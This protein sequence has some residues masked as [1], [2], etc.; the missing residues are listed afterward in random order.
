MKTSSLWGQPQSRYYSYLRRIE[1]PDAGG[2][3]SLA[4]VG[5]AD[6]KYVLPAARRGFDVWAVDVDDVAINGGTKHDDAGETHMPGLV[7]RL[8][9]EGLTDRVDVTCGDF[10]TTRPARRFDG[11]FTSGALQ[12]SFN[13]EHLLADMVEQVLNLA[14]VGGY[15]YFD[16][17]LPMEEKYRGRQNC[18]EREWWSG[19]FAGRTDV[20]VLYHR[21]LPPVMD[22]AHV[23]YPVDHYHQWGHLLVRRAA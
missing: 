13:K 12:Y 3:R 10:M 9:A 4:V 19:H 2:R 5:C 22:K 20:D 6:G 1:P 7:S 18:P 17:M 8:E 16:Y 14:R 21:V 11:V 15:V 23:E